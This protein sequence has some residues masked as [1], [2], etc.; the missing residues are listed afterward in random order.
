M[1]R[2]SGFDASFG[3]GLSNQPLVFTQAYQIGIELDLF[4]NPTDGY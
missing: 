3:D 2:S 1:S 4:T